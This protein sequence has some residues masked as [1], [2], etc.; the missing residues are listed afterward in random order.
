MSLRTRPA[1]R[2]SWALVGAALAVLL[3]AAVAFAAPDR[4]FTLSASTASVNWDGTPGTGHILPLVDGYDGPSAC[5]KEESNHC[6][7]TLL[8]VESGGPVTLHAE[9][10]SYSPP[11]SDF[12]LYIYPAD[13]SG[14]ATSDEELHPSFLDGGD[15]GWFHGFPESATVENAPPGYYLIVVVYYDTNNGTYK[16]TASIEGATPVPGGGGGDPQPTPDPGGGGGSPQPTPTPA[17]GGGG[18]T[19][20]RQAPQIEASVTPSRDAKPP[21]KFTAKGKIVP[22]AG[23]SQS[24][25]CQGR[26]AVQVKAGKKTISNRRTAVKP[27]CTWSSRL[28]ISNRKRLGKTKS[29]RFIANFQGNKVLLPRKAKT[30]TVRVR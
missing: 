10:G 21:F 11:T 15:S 14:K 24:D 27:D 9:I 26:V 18:G 16:G 25:A 19:T 28:T 3:V 8:K 29:L 7:Q 30:R 17:P 12:D 22:P 1:R 4:S 5:T 13:A 2:A 6:D 20:T 23:V